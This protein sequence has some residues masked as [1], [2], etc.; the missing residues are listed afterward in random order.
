MC[1]TS[2]LISALFFRYIDR[3]SSTTKFRNV[4]L[5]FVAE[6]SGFR[7]ISLDFVGYPGL[8]SQDAA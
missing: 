3:L 4:L 1:S 8:V 2:L 6:Q 7:W 5:S